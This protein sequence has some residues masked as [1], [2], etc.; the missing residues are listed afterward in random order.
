V[1][2]ALGEPITSMIDAAKGNATSGFLHSIMT[3]DMQPADRRRKFLRRNEQCFPKMQQAATLRPPP[4]FWKK[5]YAITSGW[6]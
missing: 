4:A 3:A 2:F 5:A 1:G 6:C